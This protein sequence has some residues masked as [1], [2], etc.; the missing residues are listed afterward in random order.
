MCELPYEK[1]WIASS[2]TF[3][4]HENF[5]ISFFKESALSLPPIAS[6]VCDQSFY[7]VVVSRF[8]AADVSDIIVSTLLVLLAVQS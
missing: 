4:S 7:F 1:Y 2:N 5:A 8:I 3:F 6:R